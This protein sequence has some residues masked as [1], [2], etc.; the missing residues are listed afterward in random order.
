MA[1]TQQRC[2]LVLSGPGLPALFPLLGAVG[3]L[4]EAGWQPVRTAGVSG[5]AIVAGLVATDAGPQELQSL[6]GALDLLPLVGR[7][8]GRRSGIVSAAPTRPLVLWLLELL[9]DRGVRTF[10]DLRIADDGTES[11]VRLQVLVRQGLRTVRRLPQDARE[12]GVNPDLLEVA[13]VLAA[14]VSGVVF[15]PVRLPGSDVDC[16][17]AVGGP[18]PLEAF[19]RTDGGAPLWPTIGVFAEM[20][21]QPGDPPLRA[22]LSATDA[23]RTIVVRDL[24]GAAS[25]LDLPRSLRDELYQ[26]GR[27]AAADWLTDWDFGAYLESRGA[28][29]TGAAPAAA[30]PSSVP[31][32]PAPSLALAGYASDSIFGPD[33]LDIAADVQSLCTVLM[34]ERVEPPL[35]VGL[36]GDWGSGKSF[37]MQKMRETIDAMAADSRAARDVG[38]HSDFCENV[39][40]VTFN[41]WHY[42][43]ANLWASLVTTLF[44][45]LVG[46]S[47]SG[48]PLTGAE[49]ADAERRRD[50]LLGRLHTAELIKSDAV[51]RLGDAQARLDELER[52]RRVA[53]AEHSQLVLLGRQAVEQALA[54][55]PQLAQRAGQAAGANS[56]AGVDPSTVA[57]LAVDVHGTWSA[58]AHTWSFASRSRRR[59]IGALVLL[60][61]PVA[62]LVVAQRDVLSA[63]LAALLPLIGACV[64]Y[65][66]EV[67]RVR[68][69]AEATGRVV[70]DGLARRRADL[71]EELAALQRELRSS[72]DTVREAQ[73]EVDDVHAGRRVLPFLEQRLT[74]SDYARHLGII[75]MVRKDL[76]RLSELMTAGAPPDDLERIDRMVLYIDDLDRCPAQ[77]VVEVLQ[78]VHL[79]LAFP[80]FV[81]VVGVDSR[82]L[83]RALELEFRDMMG[84]PDEQT[85]PGQALHWAAT[86]QNYLDKIFQIPMSLRPMDPDGYARL[87]AGLAG[88]A[89]TDRGTP[90]G[91]AGERRD[92]DRARSAD[93]SA[94]SLPVAATPAAA[95]DLSGVPAVSPHSRV[96]LDRRVTGLAF[97]AADREIRLLTAVGELVRVDARTGRRLAPD[98]AVAAVASALSA[99]GRQVVRSHAGGAVTA[100]DVGAAPAA[101]VLTAEP[102]RAVALSARAAVLAL[103]TA[104]EVLSVRPGRSEPLLRQAMTDVEQ[105]WALPDGGVVARRGRTLEL[106]GPDGATTLD[107]DAAVAAVSPDGRLLAIAGHDELRLVDLSD[108]AVAL[109]ATAVPR[110]GALAFSADGA[111]LAV[112]TA[113]DVLVLDVFT[114]QPVV[115]AACGGPAEQIAF[116]ASG[117]MLAVV[118][119]TGLLVVPV[120]PAADLRASILDLSAD[121]H[122]CLAGL[123][124]LVRTPRAAKRLVNV[125]RILRAQL[126]EGALGA[127]HP[128]VLLLLALCNA[129]PDQGALLVE[130][131]VRNPGSDWSSHLTSCRQAAPVS[132]AAMWQAL[133]DSV[134]RLPAGSVPQEIAPYRTW[135][136]HVARFSFRAGR[137]ATT[138]P[139]PA[140]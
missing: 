114:G 23:L 96:E 116:G 91:A 122:G 21:L 137:L 40:Q 65:A 35:S 51:A 56:D 44:E 29:G 132:Q 86:P 43:D 83:L 71:E 30:E 14:A 133:C 130:A 20:P 22:S 75:A 38:A 89:S 95:L 16:T 41:A 87:V 19:D 62:A 117:R 88:G 93:Q 100:G 52:K 90:G 64:A 3:V 8:P 63:A 85:D 92:G 67:G 28:R 112:G 74:S 99:D 12:I 42:V 33:R 27:K 15:E 10:G 68:R 31:L 136:P 18:F 2:D 45:G 39:R 127:D 118:V 121:E 77:R 139:A 50:E 102:A 106:L 37:F 129:F 80:L 101:P 59:V 72:Q 73:A 111:R 108:P 78:A 126:P 13:P 97:A 125:Y 32:P 82:W 113:Q 105:V 25:S 104:R 58:L 6:G 55:D 76:D 7:A 57:Q 9:G 84:S 61:V 124:P 120:R 70:T 110:I 4:L 1:E 36:F 135:A 60:V 79:L 103:A 119:G 24:P 69:A 26:R 131:L 107:Q 115:R 53:S 140:T 134:A 11:R 34:A 109:D 49:Q 128:A 54:Q 98:E 94:D 66:P 46:R 5:G 17:D 48:V 138:S 81:V 47:E 123:L